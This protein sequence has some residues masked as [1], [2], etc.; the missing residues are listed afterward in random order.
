MA[1]NLLNIVHQESKPIDE[2]SLNSS[3]RNAIVRTI[4]KYLESNLLAC[5]KAIR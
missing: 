1:S 4:L 5:L 3:A 2:E